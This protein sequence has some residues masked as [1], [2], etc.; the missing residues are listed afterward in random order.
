MVIL[1]TSLG[2]W[3]TYSSNHDGHV[4]RG[5]VE[6]GGLSCFG[7]TVATVLDLLCRQVFVPVADATA[8]IQFMQI[9]S[10]ALAFKGRGSNQPQ[11]RETSEQQTQ[12]FIHF[13]RPTRPSRPG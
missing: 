13:D 10:T 12:R 7:S 1:A 6:I 8:S 5:L 3:P 11:L 4:A 9:D 2:Y